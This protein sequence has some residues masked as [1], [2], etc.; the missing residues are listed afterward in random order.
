MKIN[1]ENRL[2]RK[3]SP[4]TV[5]MFVILTLFSVAL[6]GILFWTVITSLKPEKLADFKQR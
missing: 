5:I 3:F 1:K 6:I 4:L 2:T